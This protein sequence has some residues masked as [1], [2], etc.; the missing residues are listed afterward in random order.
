MGKN[1]TTQI[2]DGPGEPGD[3]VYRTYCYDAYVRLLTIAYVRTIFW[4]DARILYIDQRG[5]DIVH[6]YKIVSMCF[7]GALR[8]CGRSLLF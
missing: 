7:S 4:Y 2:V 3:Y 1:R 6:T 8:E 5:I